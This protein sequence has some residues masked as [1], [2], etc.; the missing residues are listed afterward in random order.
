MVGISGDGFVALVLLGSPFVQSHPRWTIKS[1]P[2]RKVYKFN[3]ESTELEGLE[4]CQQYYQQHAKGKP[5]GRTISRAPPR[6][7]KLSCG[8]TVRRWLVD[9]GHAPS[10][11]CALKELNESAG[12]PNRLAQRLATRSGWL[13]SRDDFQARGR[14][15]DLAL[16][17]PTTRFSLRP[18][19]FD[20]QLLGR[21]SLSRRQTR[22][23]HAE[24]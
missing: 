24:G 19:A 4:R 22:R 13:V 6:S 11:F 1:T 18:S 10:G 5:R 7:N 14:A 17:R 23:Q 20:L 9:F 2:C 12:R 8:F 3:M 21:S 15:A 16:S